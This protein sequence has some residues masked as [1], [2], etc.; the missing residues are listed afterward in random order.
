MLRHV[1]A[2]AVLLHSAFA[3][4]PQAGQIKN[5]V[6]FGDSYT[7]IVGSIPVLSERR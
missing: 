6:T 4:G 1:L 3:A 2:A 7:D 5:L